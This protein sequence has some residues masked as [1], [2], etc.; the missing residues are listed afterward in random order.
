MHN[1]DVTA[2]ILLN[3]E[4]TFFIFC[5][6]NELGEIWCGKNI[7]CYNLSV[8]SLTAT[9]SAQTAKQ[10]FEDRKNVHSVQRV[11]FPAACLTDNDHCISNAPVSS[12]KSLTVWM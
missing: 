9:F 4:S 10:F 12:F 3:G 2:Q 11:L 7:I 1:L 6:F 8:M 5:D